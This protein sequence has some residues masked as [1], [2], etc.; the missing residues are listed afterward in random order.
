[1]S[2]R[3][4]SVTAF[5]IRFVDDTALEV[6]DITPERI[7][8]T[9]R[10]IPDPFRKRD[11]IPRNS[12]SFSA[13]TVAP[14]PLSTFGK[15]SPTNKN[16]YGGSKIPM[17]KGYSTSGRRSKTDPLL[18]QQKRMSS[19]SMG[20]SDTSSST[21]TENTYSY[22]G[23]RKSPSSQQKNVKYSIKNKKRGFSGEDNSEQE[24][25][26]KYSKNNY[27]N[28]D[29]V[30]N[31]R[32]TSSSSSSLIADKS[33]YN[34]GNYSRYVDG[35]T[36]PPATPPL[37]PPLSPTNNKTDSYA[38][39]PSP[40]NSS[41]IVDQMVVSDNSSE[42]IVSST[43]PSSRKL[44]PICTS[45]TTLASATNDDDIELSP[46]DEL[47]PLK[48]PMIPHDEV[49]VPT[50]AKR[51]KKQE[52]FNEFQRYSVPN[53]PTEHGYTD[54]T[55]YVEDLF[56]SDKKYPYTTY[57]RRKTSV[58][59][60]TPRRNTRSRQNSAAS[61]TRPIVK[62][63]QPQTPSHAVVDHIRSQPRINNQNN[64]VEDNDK[65]E[66]SENGNSAADTTITNTSDTGA[67]EDPMRVGRRARRE[68]WVMV[69]RD[70]DEKSENSTSTWNGQPSDENSIENEVGR[71]EE[72]IQNVYSGRVHQSQDCTHLRRAQR[73][74]THTRSTER[75]KQH[76]R[77]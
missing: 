74:T 16:N 48:K 53:S 42:T 77:S 37:S 65:E 10:H 61:R 20:D 25:H 6:V 1:M 26:R 29:D 76:R 50:V 59:T 66:L 40:R 28:D 45:P 41:I 31:E 62:N 47:P 49:I 35:L 56:D 7:P 33:H 27:N 32:V 13:T 11:K 51:L 63:H 2:E 70:D 21:A 72:D 64:K 23:G 19:A 38:A 8:P 12:G 68:E 75:P 60:S 15:D 69:V 5:E 39:E 3:R 22:I 44:P 73:K 52:Q 36:T 24:T 58:S 71:I 30:I 17:R 67:A 55:D 14:E 43:P 9:E 57:P 54:I 34:S 18:S 4:N 46:S